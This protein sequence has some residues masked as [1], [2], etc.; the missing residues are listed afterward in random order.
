MGPD[1]SDESQQER[2]VSANPFDR[3]AG[4]DFQYRR[5]FPHE[6]GVTRRDPSPVIERDGL[7]HVWYSRNVAGNALPNH[8][9]TATIWHATSEDGVH[10]E[11]EGEAIGR[12]DSGSFDECGVFTPT[13]LATGGKY[14]LYYTAMPI[15]WKRYRQT[16]KGAVGVAVA[17]SPYGPWTKQPESPVLRCSDDPDAFDSL[18]VDDTCIVPRNGRYWMYYKGR[19]WDTSPQLTKMG[20]A[21]ADDPLGPWTKYDGNPVLNSGHEV[22]VW[23]HGDGVACLVSDSG[24]QGNT[25]QYSDDGIHFWKA[26]DADPPKAPGPYRRDDFRDGYGPGITWG[27]CVGDAGTDWPSLLRFDCRLESPEPEDAG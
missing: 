27:L 20:L 5:V 13:I 3:L 4:Y 12:G 22:C 7:Y 11:E 14:Y 9:F 21:R 18:R 26:A 8:G 24:L 6:E 23:P 16:T 19:Q 2:K 10:W 1:R 17:D 15:E 25:L